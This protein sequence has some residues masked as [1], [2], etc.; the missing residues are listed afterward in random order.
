MCIRTNFTYLVSYCQA[1]NAQLPRN[2]VAWLRVHFVSLTMK[3]GKAVEVLCGEPSW[4]SIR[5]AKIPVFI[6]CAERDAARMVMGMT[7]L[8]RMLRK[9]KALHMLEHVHGNIHNDRLKNLEPGGYLAALI[10]LARRLTL[11]IDNNANELFL[12]LRC[13]TS[14]FRAPGA[15]LCRPQEP[16]HDGRLRLQP[17]L[18]GLQLPKL[19][20]HTEAGLSPF[21]EV[22]NRDRCTSMQYRR[23]AISYD[24]LCLRTRTMLTTLALPRG[25]CEFKQYS[26]ATVGKVHEPRNRKSYRANAWIT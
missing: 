19:H 18:G 26:M 11:R 20:S 10:T 2:P 14:S 15:H 16:H 8:S 22:V 21:L 12:S 9:A 24:C 23:L 17:A 4:R 5:A 7:V 13:S 1:V 3:T 25:T 6:T